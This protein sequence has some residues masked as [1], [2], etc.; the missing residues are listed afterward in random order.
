MPLTQFTQIQYYNSES[1]V[2]GLAEDMAGECVCADFASTEQAYIKRFD[3]DNI[4]FT[5][6]CAYNVFLIFRGSCFLMPS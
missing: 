6:H 4:R 1:G 3:I 2:I 5:H